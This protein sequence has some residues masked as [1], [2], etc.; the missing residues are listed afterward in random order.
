MDD[1]CPNLILHTCPEC[2]KKFIPAPKHVFKIGKS[3]ACSYHCHR[4]YQ[5]RI[6]ERNKDKIRSELE[7]RCEK[8]RIKQEMAKE[9]SMKASQRGIRFDENGVPSDHYILQYTLDGDF[10][11]S[12]ASANEAALGLPTTGLKIAR[13]ARGETSQAGGYVWK[14]TRS[15]NSRKR[16]GRS[17]VPVLQMNFFEEIVAEYKNMKSA[18]EATGINIASISKAVNGKMYQAGGFLWAAKKY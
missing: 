2:G 9:R 8:D 16:R 14:Y 11:D 12:Y 5:K 15:W 1:C 18:S 6:E 10:V 13:C 4:A 17:D 7:S 3:Y